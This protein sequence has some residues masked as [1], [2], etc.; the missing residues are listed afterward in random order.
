MSALLEVRNV[1]S[2][3]RR[4]FV[5]LRGVSLRVREEEMVALLG[6]N[7][8]GKTTLLRTLMGLIPDQPEKGEVLFQGQR[9]QGKEPHEITRMG[10]VLVPEGRGIFPEL[11]VAENLALAGFGRRIWAGEVEAVLDRFPVLRERWRQL[12][13]TLSGGEQQ[14]LALARALVLRPR[15]LL[16]DEPSLGLAPR[17]AAEIF[18]ALQAL[19][20]EGMAVLLVEQNARVALRIAHYG[21][22]LEA[23][24]L[25][26]EGSAE[27]L[28]ED[29][30]VQA[31]YLGMGGESSPKGFRR[32]RP[33]RRWA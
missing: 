12:A 20:R 14:M 31:L 18:A 27:R 26:L 15:L 3:Y 11:T 28:R 10:M 8:A 4:G 5:V 29:P 16:L 25:V 1:E 7:G 17:V 19:N 2:G 9:L 23:G 21:Y 24:R 6:P 30:N 13:G 32:W 22:V 33:K